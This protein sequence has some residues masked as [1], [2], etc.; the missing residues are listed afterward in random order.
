MYTNTAL[1]E[2]G[3]NVQKF[4]FALPPWP[5][6]VFAKFTQMHLLFWTISFLE[7]GQKISFPHL[8]TFRTGLT[9]GPCPCPQPNISSVSCVWWGN[10]LHPLP[11]AYK[12]V[13]S[14]APQTSKN[15]PPLQG[16]K[17]T[18]S[19]EDFQSQCTGNQPSCRYLLNIAHMW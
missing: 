4:P 10:S 9:A 18:F 12:L 6:F 17:H 19:L 16:L 5:L 13:E 7:K 3:E 11:P 15:V 2:D 14:R 1:S 8:P